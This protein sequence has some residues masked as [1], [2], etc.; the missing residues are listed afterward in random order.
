MESFEDQKWALSFERWRTPAL[1]AMDTMAEVKGPKGML[2]EEG[3]ERVTEQERVN[4]GL[5]FSRWQE[6]YERCQAGL[7]AVGIDSNITWQ[8]VAGGWLEEALT[9]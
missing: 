7:L 1:Y 3:K 9:S 4:L 6:L 2:A 5:A 8:C